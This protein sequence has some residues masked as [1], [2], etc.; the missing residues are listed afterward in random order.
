LGGQ[1]LIALDVRLV[2]ATHREIDSLVAD[3]KFRE[4]LYYRLNVVPLRVP[5]LRERREDIPLLVAH[6]LERAQDR[7]GKKP[8]QIAP[9]AMRALCDYPWPGNIRQLRNCMER[10]VVTVER[11]TFHT[12]DLPEE[13]R[14]VPRQGP[15]TVDEAVQ[16]AEKAAILEALSQCNQHRERAAHLLGI[17]VRTLHYKLNRHTIS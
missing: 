4:D 13:I 7:Y 16:Q 2:S 1:E 11:P 17:S 14:V 8:T 5:P 10:L 9:G 3:G 6:F 12:D 15:M